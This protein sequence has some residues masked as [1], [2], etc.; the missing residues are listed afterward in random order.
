MN[1]QVIEKIKGAIE[2]LNLKQRADAEQGAAALRKEAQ[3]HGVD[4]HD[5]TQ[6]EAF[7]LAWSWLYMAVQSPDRAENFHRAVSATGMFFIEEGLPNG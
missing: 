4:L 2:P 7:M 3:N 5:P 6:L 1:P